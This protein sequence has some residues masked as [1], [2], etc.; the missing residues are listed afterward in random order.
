MAECCGQERSGNFCS[1]CGKDMRDLK[2]SPALRV[3]ECV[4]NALAGLYEQQRT[5]RDASSGL[6]VKRDLRADIAKCRIALA[7]VGRMMKLEAAMAPSGVK[8]L[9]DGTL[10]P[11]HPRHTPEQLDELVEIL[12]RA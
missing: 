4:E 12:R 7:W 2:H 9:D 6:L 10:V 1:E 5:Y 11:N 3:R 8:E